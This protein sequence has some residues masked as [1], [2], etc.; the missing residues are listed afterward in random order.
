[1]DDRTKPAFT[2]Q[3]LVAQGPSL[4]DPITN[5]VTPPVHMSTTYLRD[6]DNG[7]RAGYIY[8]RCDNLSVQQAESLIAALEG[9]DEALLFGSGMRP[10]PVCCSR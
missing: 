1:M 8:G 6:P 4:R 3:T 5:A 7:Y 9:A 10:R 2:V